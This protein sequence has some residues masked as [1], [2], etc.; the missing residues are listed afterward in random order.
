MHGEVPYYRERTGLVS[1]SSIRGRCGK[2]ELLLGMV[3]TSL[4]S[5]LPQVVG[6]DKCRRGFLACAMV[7][8]SFGVGSGGISFQS[9]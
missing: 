6:K 9:V 2:F 4:P 5:L 7:R 1:P 3:H 8:D